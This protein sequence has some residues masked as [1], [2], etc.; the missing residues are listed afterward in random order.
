MQQ[1]SFFIRY[2]KQITL[3][4]IVGIIFCIATVI[5]VSIQKYLSQKTYLTLQFAPSSAILALADGTE[6]TTGTREFT[7]GTYAGTLS[8]KGF[9]PKEIT[10]QVH[11]H[12]T[13]GFSDYL[14]NDAEGLTYYEK[15]A[16]DISTLHQ[17]A[18]QDNHDDPELTNFLE[19][20]DHK[21]SLYDLLPL[22]ISWLKRP[23]D[24][25]T[26]SLK[27]TN[28]TNYSQCQ[29]TLCLLTTGPNYNPTELEKALSERGYNIND[30]EVFYEYSAI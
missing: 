29:S 14:V 6:L 12:Q 17:I 9:S 19:A 30:Y 3:V 28:G 2:S 4:A 5:I 7:P 18:R 26:Y 25:P 11:A 23:D 8:A 20:Y 16:A 10:F 13:N 24:T 15:N 1:E 22:I 27:I 21:T